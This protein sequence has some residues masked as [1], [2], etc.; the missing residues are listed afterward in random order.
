MLVHA[1][2]ESARSFYMHHGFEP[3]PVHDMTLMLKLW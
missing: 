3:S 1:L 2:S